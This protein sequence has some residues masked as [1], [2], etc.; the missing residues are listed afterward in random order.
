MVYSII[1]SA[2][3]N[4]KKYV[5]LEMMR[6]NFYDFAQTTKKFNFLTNT[7]KEKCFIS[8]IR[9][10]FTSYN[11]P[12]FF[13]YKYDFESNYKMCKLINIKIRNRQQDSS[14]KPI[15]AD[16]VPMPEKTSRFI[17]SM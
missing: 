1:I 17:K 6:E 8:Q 12:D 2:K 4:S 10:A 3:I 13:F 11:M 9:E 16:S 14:L 5:V 15:Y 7:E